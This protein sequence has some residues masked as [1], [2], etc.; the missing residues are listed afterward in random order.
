MG[1]QLVA[2]GGRVHR[3]PPEGRLEADEPAEAGRNADR[4]GA[5]GA[6]RQRPQ[7]GRDGG[8]SAA[9]RSAGR[10]SEVP[11]IARLAE[12]R[13]VGR[14]APGE[15]RQIGPAHEDRAGRPQR[16]TLG[17]SSGGTKSASRR[18][19]N[20]VRSPAVQRLSLIESGTPWSGPSGW[21]AITACSAAAGFLQSSLGVD[22]R[23]RRPG[24]RSA[25]RS[26]PARRG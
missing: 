15:L 21:P 4:A 11:G 7:A 5:V 3:H 6:E 14:A 20:V 17:A 25:A 16:A 2:P 9:R 24:A 13:I 22:Q 10:A 19:P 18:E 1:D 12:E 23:R 8:G 26:A